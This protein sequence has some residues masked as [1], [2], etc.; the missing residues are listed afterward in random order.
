MLTLPSWIYGW[1]FFRTGA[2]V[3]D[4]GTGATILDWTSFNVANRNSKT[5]KIIKNIFGLS[6]P[7]YAQIKTAT[8]SPLQALLTDA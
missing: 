6:T 1:L 3:D 4:A 2:D 5:S 8:T 7:S